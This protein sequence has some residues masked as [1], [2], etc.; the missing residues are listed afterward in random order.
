MAALKPRFFAAVDSL[1]GRELR[2]G[3]SGYEEKIMRLDWKIALVASAIAF[4]GMA[5]AETGGAAAG[6]AAGG[7]AGAAV[8]GLAGA[9]IGAGVG[10]AAGDAASG[11]D[12]ENVT[13]ERRE[14]ESTGSVGCETVT[15]QRS[16]ATGDTVT[17]QRTD[18]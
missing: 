2:S 17:R 9:A 18:C 15:T 8:G 7:A 1:K 14:I 12:Q 5:F 13:I 10:G 6:A 11:P 16:D 4:P 3:Y